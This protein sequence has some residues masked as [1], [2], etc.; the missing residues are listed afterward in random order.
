MAQVFPRINVIAIAAPPLAD[1]NEAALLQFVDNFLHG[2]FGYAH[3]LRNVAQAR[4]VVVSE[5]DQNVPMVA[6]YRPFAHHC[7]T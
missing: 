2:P 1:G 5:A 6:E 4:F 7:L 3:L